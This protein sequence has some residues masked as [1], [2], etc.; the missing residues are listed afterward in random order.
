MNIFLQ[1]ALSIVESKGKL[2]LIKAGN[3]WYDKHPDTVESVLTIVYPVIDVEIE[4]HVK[5]TSSPID[6]R[7]IKDLKEVCEA[8]AE[9][10]GFD[11]PNVDAD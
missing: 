10:G 3:Q 8:I 4:N 6:D 9:H 5:E 2:E 1:A 11:L 7:V